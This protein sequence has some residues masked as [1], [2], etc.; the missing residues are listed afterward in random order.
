MPRPVH[1][2]IPVQNPERAM[3]FYGAVLGWTFSKF[4]GPMPYWLITTGPNDEPGVNGGMLPRRDPAQ[5]SVNTVNVTDLDATAA[6]IQAHGG[7][8][9][10]PKMAIPGV[11]WLAYF[12]DLDGHCFGVM[13]LDSAAA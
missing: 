7:N 11:G 6:T 10:I 2:E 8:C 1:F 9:I 5:P 13:Q 4:E 3:A 12:N